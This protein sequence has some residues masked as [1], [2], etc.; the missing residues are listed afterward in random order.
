MKIKSEELD[1]LHLSAEARAVISEQ[2]IS[3]LAQ[4]QQWADYRNEEFYLA[5]RDK[6]KELREEVYRSVARFRQ[7]RG[8]EF[9][10]RYVAYLD[11][12]GF[13]R[14]VE[15]ANHCDDA[16]QIIRSSL[17]TFLDIVS[18]HPNPELQFSQFSDN[19]VLSASRDENGLFYIMET[20]IRLSFSLFLQGVLVRGGIA[21]GNL[22]HTEHLLF[23]SGLINAYRQDTRGGPPRITLEDGF[24]ADWRASRLGK[25]T[26]PVAVREDPFDLSSIVHTLLYAETYSPMMLGQ[27]PLSLVDAERVVALMKGHSTDMNAPPD[28]RAKWRWMA[29]YWN[30]AAS[31]GGHLPLV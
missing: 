2:G 18:K 24:L 16:R 27:H 11:I 13:S 10:E 23:G 9:Q 17:R 5:F 1:H 8:S 31:K 20:C 14:L 7:L 19:L 12:L 3:T 6:P 30:S 15:D 25:E 29:D 28:V 21:L 22:E 26:W 4:I